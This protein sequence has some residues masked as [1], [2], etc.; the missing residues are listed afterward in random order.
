M[1][2]TGLT[3]DGKIQIDIRNAYTGWNRRLLIADD[4]SQ[5]IAPAPTEEVIVRMQSTS[6]WQGSAEGATILVGSAAGLHVIAVRE[7]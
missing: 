2:L 1:H 3:A 6:T 5:A 4:G 7:R